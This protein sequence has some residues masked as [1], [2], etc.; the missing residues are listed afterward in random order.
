MCRSARRRTHSGIVALNSSVWRCAGHCRRIRST[1][2]AKPMSSMRSASSSTQMRTFARVRERRWMWSPSRPGVA[3]TMCAPWRNSSIWRP[4]EFA[5]VDGDA[6]QLVTLAEP[7]QLLVHLDRKL[8]CGAEH[9]RLH[10]T[11]AR[12]EPLDDRNAERRGLAAAGLRLADDVAAGEREGQR[13]CLDRAWPSCSRARP[14][15]AAWRRSTRARRSSPA[16]GFQYSGPHQPSQERRDEALRRAVYQTAR[17]KTNARQESVY[18]ELA[19]SRVG[20][21]ALMPADVFR[22]RSDRLTALGR[23]PDCERASVVRA[24]GPGARPRRHHRR[25]PAAA[26]ARAFATRCERPRRGCR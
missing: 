14:R 21:I 16:R 23:H 12:I 3:T 7:R 18:P 24:A 25:L 22:T 6:L 20:K 8:S 10:R 5:A 13:A 4:I 26:A 9:E 19:R 1:S 2:G 11:V 17:E 15:C